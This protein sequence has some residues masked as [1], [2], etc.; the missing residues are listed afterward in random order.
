MG[1]EQAVIAIGVGCRKG[2]PAEEIVALVREAV[3]AL[4]A[5]AKPGGVFSIEEKRGEAGLAEAA[6]RLDLPLGFFDASQLTSFAAAAETVSPRIERM[7]GLPSVAETAALAGAGDGAVLLVP[8]RASARATCAIAG[9][10]FRRSA[11]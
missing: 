6:A 2:C 8:R 10:P 5:D 7:H 4:P 3:A 11:P 1:G 9:R